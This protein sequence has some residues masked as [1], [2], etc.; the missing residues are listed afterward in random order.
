MQRYRILHRTYYSFDDIVLLGQHVLRLRPRESHELRIEASMLR[1]T[2]TAS[3]LW[4]RDVDDNSVATA[5]FKTSANQILFESDII[6]QQFNETPLNFVV[7]G[8]A[9][10]YPFEYTAEERIGLFAYIE[11]A[12]RSTNDSLDDWISG[13]WIYGERVQTYVMLQSINTAINESFRY[14]TRE[15]PGVQ[16]PT[17]T[18]AIGS[19]SC[20][21]FAALFIAAARRLGLAA[22]FLSGYLKAAPSSMN[23]GATHA[24]AEVYLPGAGW[25]GFDPTLGKIVGADH[26]AVAVAREPESVPPIEGSFTGYAGSTMNVGVWV[27]ELE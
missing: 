16:S 27:T 26:I 19:G 3:V 2:P 24:W 13:F 25:K 17:E 7:A 1:I 10:D 9:M 12:Y 18:L 20:R 8:Y 23:F 15:E 6:V 22:R 21:D 4:H 5:T 11:Q 14:T